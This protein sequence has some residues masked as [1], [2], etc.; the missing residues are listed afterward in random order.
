MFRRRALPWFLGGLALAA[1]YEVP[2]SDDDYTN[3]IC[4]GMWGGKEAGINGVH[5]KTM[6]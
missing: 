6:I 5:F 3:Q 4:S 2:I 1:A